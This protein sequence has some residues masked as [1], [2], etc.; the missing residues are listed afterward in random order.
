MEQEQ[1]PHKLQLNE[2]RQLTMTGVTEVVSF[3]EGGVV[4]QTSLGPPPHP[5]ALRA[6]DHPHNRRGGA[7][8]PEASGGRAGG[9]GRLVGVHLSG[10][11]GVCRGP[12]AGVCVGTSGRG[13]GVGGHRRTMAPTGIFRNL[14]NTG[15]NV[16]AFLGTW[17]K[18]FAI[19]ENFVCIW[20]KMGYNKVETLSALPTR[21]RRYGPWQKTS[22]PENS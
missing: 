5:R 14:A 20:G 7:D 3:D 15:D 19:Y 13:G 11:R 22:I 6:G 16:G 8:R 4:L 9:A 2:R 12:A 10:L 1:L 17:E 21:S 18:I